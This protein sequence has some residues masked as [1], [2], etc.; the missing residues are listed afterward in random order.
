[1]DRTWDFSTLTGFRAAEPIKIKGSYIKHDIPCMSHYSHP[2]T[3]LLIAHPSCPLPGAPHIQRTVCLCIPP[4]VIQT[5]PS[6]ISSSSASHIRRCVLCQSPAT[7]L[8]PAQQAAAKPDGKRQSSPCPFY[9]WKTTEV[10]SLYLVAV[11]NKIYGNIRH[12]QDFLPLQSV[13][14]RMDREYRQ[15]NGEMANSLLSLRKQTRKI[16]LY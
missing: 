4:I 7:C 15:K 9:P 12:L 13:K 1:M 6:Y 14:S 8:P 10:C 2:S 3:T 11:L 16:L 5:F